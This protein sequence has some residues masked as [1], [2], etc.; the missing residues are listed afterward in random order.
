MRN[1]LAAGVLCVV[2]LFSVALAQEKSPP[3]KPRTAEEIFATTCG[4]CH[5]KGGREAGK[6]PKLM[7]TT[8]TDAEI[9][10]RIRKGK[11]GFMPSFE[12]TFSDGELKGLVSYIR[13]LKP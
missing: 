12:S 13:T 11:Q 1:E 4:W 8:L 2:T 9:I 6:G 3:A 10:Y 7:G 5:H